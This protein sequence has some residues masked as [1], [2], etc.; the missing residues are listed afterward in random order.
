MRAA[1]LGLQYKKVGDPSAVLGDVQL[2]NLSSD[3][4][5]DFKNQVKTEISLLMITVV[6]T[7]DELDL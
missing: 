5:K 7:D 2:Y 6:V 1:E 4:Q 3:Y